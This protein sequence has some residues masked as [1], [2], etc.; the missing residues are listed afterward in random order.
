MNQ[1]DIDENI[2][3][4]IQYIE[5]DRYFFPISWEL[6]VNR[7]YSTVTVTVVCCSQR[8]Y[9][10]QSIFCC[11]VHSFSWVICVLLDVFL[12]NILKMLKCFLEN[13]KLIT[14]FIYI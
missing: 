9:W 6:K 14:Y 5:S 10:K 1:I 7:Y 13:S 3:K 12:E 2:W 4:Y 11:S 8:K